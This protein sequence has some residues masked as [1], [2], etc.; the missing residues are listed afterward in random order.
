[1]LQA[2]TFVK[3]G[4]NDDNNRYRVKQYST[5]HKDT[6][7]VNTCFN[8]DPNVT[9]ND[10]FDSEKCP[11]PAE[12]CGYFK[13]PDNDEIEG[14]CILTQYCDINASIWEKPPDRNVK[15]RANMVDYKCGDPKAIKLNKADLADW[16]SLLQNDKYG[17]PGQSLRNCYKKYWDRSINTYFYVTQSFCDFEFLYVSQN[18]YY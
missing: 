8:K 10:R 3:G 13:Y 16:T 2:D 1:L 18:Q 12:S 17:V 9:G 5:W 4:K 11:N 7:S 6:G 14:G 15:V